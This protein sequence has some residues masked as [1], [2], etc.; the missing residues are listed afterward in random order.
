MNHKWIEQGPLKQLFPDI[1]SLNQQQNSTIEM[2][3]GELGWNLSFRRALNDWEIDKLAS[4]YGTLEQFKGTS[5]EA[6]CLIWLRSKQN[7][8][9]LKAELHP[10]Y[11]QP[12]TIRRGF[13]LGR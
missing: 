9:T 11:S 12:Q 3:W 6:D 8:F 4:F 5:S 1:Y 2:F 13:G 10:G 7:K